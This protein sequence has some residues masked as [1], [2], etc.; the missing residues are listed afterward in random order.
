MRLAERLAGPGGFAATLAGARIEADGDE[1][2]FLREAGEAA[3]G[4]LAPLT[5]AAGRTGVWDGRFEIAADMATEVRSAAGLRSDLLPA[6]QQVLA[7]L[8]ASA[9][10]T[11]PVIVAE[12]GPR[13]AEARPLALDRLLA[14]CGAAEIEPA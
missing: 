6:D 8:P 7:G 3:R 10:D 5:L 12:D 4:G 9:R 13:L 14:A 11:V 2:R 1:V